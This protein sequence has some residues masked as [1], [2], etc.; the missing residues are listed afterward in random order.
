MLKNS[1]KASITYK[2]PR[3]T[4]YYKQ[5]LTFIKVKDVCCKG[6]I[7]RFSAG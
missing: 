5:S 1:V 2:K 6:G 3:F 4:R 7:C